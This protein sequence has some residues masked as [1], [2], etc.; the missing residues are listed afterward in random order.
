MKKIGIEKSWICQY[1]ITPFQTEFKGVQI[2]LGNGIKRAFP[3]NDINFTLPVSK[4]IEKFFALEMQS[5]FESPKD[6][7]L[8]QEIIE[9]INKIECRLLFIRLVEERPLETYDREKLDDFVN[10]IFKGS[11]LK[12]AR[13]LK[14]ANQPNFPKDENF[15]L[16]HFIHKNTLTFINSFLVESKQI[17]TTDEGSFLENH[18]FLEQKLLLHQE[19]SKYRIRP[20]AGFIPLV[21]FAF[22]AASYSASYSFVRTLTFCISILC[23][24]S[25]YVI[26]FLCYFFSE[27]FA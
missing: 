24:V 15:E 21:G 25:I 22:L 6:P 11:W 8:T 13:K 9:K 2:T 3:G 27:N 10:I 16:F 4:Y 5:I 23:F 26:D 19:L 17:S 18:I 7:K 14:V 12:V 1:K 20:L